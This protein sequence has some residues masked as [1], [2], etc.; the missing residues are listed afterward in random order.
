VD[1]DHRIDER[2]DGALIG[3]SSS[4]RPS[5]WQFRLQNDETMRRCACIAHRR[6]CISETHDY[7]A[8]ERQS[9]YLR[10]TSS[11]WSS[12]SASGSRHLSAHS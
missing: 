3:G 1:I 11:M 4:I 12:T 9:R 10:R 7:D 8:D 5:L 6:N 2:E